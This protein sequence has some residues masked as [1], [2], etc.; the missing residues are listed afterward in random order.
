MVAICG[1]KRVQKRKGGQLTPKKPR[2]WTWRAKG[3]G[4]RSGTPIER[5]DDKER[6]CDD[7]ERD[8]GTVRS[9]ALGDDEIGNRNCVHG[10]YIVEPGRY[11][12][13]A[14]HWQTGR[15][16]RD[17]RLVE[18][19]NH[20]SGHVRLAGLNRTI[21]LYENSDRTELIWQ[22]VTDETGMERRPI[23]IAGSTPVNE[24]AVARA[25]DERPGNELV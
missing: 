15:K 22:I 1:A 3:I 19:Q 9:Q 2:K 6:S 25:S 24:E 4:I 23:Q 18:E 11:S 21:R 17:L 10:P 14:P 7:R 8:D 13:E 12:W 5:T 20:R 16:L